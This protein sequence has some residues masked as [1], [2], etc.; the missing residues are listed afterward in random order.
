[1]LASWEINNIFVS[2]VYMDDIADTIYQIY[3]YF[4]Q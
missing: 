2:N 4:I 3:Q 1:M